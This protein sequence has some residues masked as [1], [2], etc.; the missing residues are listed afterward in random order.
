VDTNANGLSDQWEQQYWGAG[1]ANH[2]RYTD[3]DGD[4]FSDYAEFIA[5]TNP[6]LPNSHLRVTG[7]SM[8]ANGMVLLQWPS[9]AGRIYQVQGSTDLANWTPVS[10]WIQAAAGTTSF[11]L[12]ATGPPRFYRIEVRP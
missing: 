9:V 1:G 6:T 2:N 3:G 7:Y 12:P 8:Q 5:G 10:S 11:T 4:G